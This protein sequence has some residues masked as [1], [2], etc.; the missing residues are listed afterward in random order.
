M[1]EGDK[2]STRE[3]KKI[4]SKRIMLTVFWNAEGFLIADLLP[5]GMRFNSE[6]FIN[7]IL[8]KIFKITAER[9][10]SVIEKLRFISTKLGHILQ[11]K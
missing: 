2:L 11:E 1:H 4:G 6:Y 10:L 3:K 8:E 7:N 9:E 5:E